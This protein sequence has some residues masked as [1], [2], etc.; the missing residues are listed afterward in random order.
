MLA[1]KNCPDLES[2]PVEA[3]IVKAIALKRAKV[4][5]QKYLK[6]YAKC[7]DYRFRA[8]TAKTIF[9]DHPDFEYYICGD[10]VMTEVDKEI[11][12]QDE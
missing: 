5:Y 9:F 3:E 8:V 1:P 10:D 11:S 12:N 2:K 6:V 4:L 7:E